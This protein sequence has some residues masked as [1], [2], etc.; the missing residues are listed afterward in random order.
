MIFTQ[1]CL[2]PATRERLWDF[3]MDVPAVSRCV[4]GIGNVEAVGQDTYRGSILVRV[5][6][7]RLSLEGTITVESERGRGT[8]VR[9]TMPTVR[10]AA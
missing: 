5:G 8:T 3:L 1:E 2:V 4:P 9:I 10:A 7:V 6:P